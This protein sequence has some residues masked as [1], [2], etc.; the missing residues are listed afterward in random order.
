[1]LGA[2]PARNGN[3]DTWHVMR[4]WRDARTRTIDLACGK[5][6]RPLVHHGS[7]YGE[8]PKKECM[9]ASRHERN[10]ASRRR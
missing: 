3:N 1:M 7:M 4:N 2:P 6:R 8:P 9:N 10:M 5:A